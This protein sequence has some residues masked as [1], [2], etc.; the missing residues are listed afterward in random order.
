[1][2]TING[3]LIAFL[4]IG[5]ILMISSSCKKNESEPTSSKIDPDISW[6][7]PANIP[8]G[9]TLN[10]RQLY[11]TANVSGNF[12][13]TPSIG[14]ILNVGANQDLKVVFTPTDVANYNTI[15]KTVKINVVNAGVKSTVFNSGITYGTLTDREGNV[16]KTVTI[17]TQTW[18]AENLRTTVYRDGS[19]IFEGK[20]NNDWKLGLSYGLYGNYTW[21]YGSYDN[22]TTYGMLYD[23]WA[24]NNEHKLAPEGWHV[25]TDAEWLILM[26][27]LGGENIAGGKLK[28]MG[29]THWSSPN[30]NATNETGFSGLPN[31]KISYIGSGF[32][33]E[34][35]GA[36]YYWT[37]TKVG[38]SNYD[39]AYYRVLSSPN[40]KCLRDF[41]YTGSG[42]AVRC[43][44][45]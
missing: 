22:I 6:D 20:T 35:G 26:N 45:D 24:V 1:M 18:M 44:K 25:P 16:Y 19:W 41:D 4:L 40:S 37:S 36:G 17:G 12:V 14:T 5:F 38:T 10:S 21:D 2:K 31:G 30:L 27:Y 13:Y 23:W 11:A 42:F 28:E 3:S 43:V 39:P 29:T 8:F 9:T 15:S 34:R 33:V 32:G 7:N